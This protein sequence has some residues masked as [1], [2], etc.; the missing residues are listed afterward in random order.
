MKI[1]AEKS[2]LHVAALIILLA[3]AWLI[4]P[5]VYAEDRLSKSI[6]VDSVLQRLKEKQ[7]LIPKLI[8]R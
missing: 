4:P 1:L 5:H 8:W 2:T 6:S 3:N 7:E